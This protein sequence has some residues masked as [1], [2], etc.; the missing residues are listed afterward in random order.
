MEVVGDSAEHSF[1]FPLLSI[2]KGYTK[3]RVL[4]GRTNGFS[5][6]G[7]QVCRQPEDLLK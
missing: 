7:F 2:G 4:P 1:K 3:V 6:Q 5:F